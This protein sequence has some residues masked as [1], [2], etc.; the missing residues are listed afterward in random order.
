MRDQWGDEPTAY[1]GIT[2]PN[3]PNL[4]CVYGPGTN[5]AAGASLFYHA[6]FQVHYAMEVIRETLISEARWSEVR[7]EA[8]EA[9]STAT[10]ARSVSWSGRTPPSSTATTRTAEARSLPCHRGHSISTGSGPVTSNAPTTPSAKS[11]SGA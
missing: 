8:H 9:T 7:S 1:L 6:E 2:I 5:L 3:F 11:I 10:R 4:F